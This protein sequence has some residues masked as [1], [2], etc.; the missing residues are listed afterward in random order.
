MGK[1]AQCSQETVNNYNYYTA[2]SVSPDGNYD[3]V[4]YETRDTEAD[5][6][7]MYKRYVV[8]FANFEKQTG[9]ICTACAN[10]GNGP[11]LTVFGLIIII[12]GVLSAGL[13]IGL[14]ATELIVISIIALIAGVALL[15][16]G[17]NMKKIR[18]PLSA[19]RGSAY[20]VSLAGGNFFHDGKI[21]R[22]GN[23]VLF[24]VAEYERCKK[25]QGRNN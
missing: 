4:I 16:Y 23:K 9:F 17:I 20:L 19:D 1:C 2:D 3:D 11:V 12:I 21:E 22:I 5:L 15:Y 18:K 25:T 7:G 8:A 14:G 13:V 24:T 10:K 6:G